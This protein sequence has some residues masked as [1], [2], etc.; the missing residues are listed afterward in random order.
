MTSIPAGVNPTA[1]FEAVE[2][3]KGDRVRLAKLVASGSVQRVRGQWALPLP[4][5]NDRGMDTVRP[6]KKNRRKR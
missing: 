1:W 6:N 4:V 2:R 3:A 5:L